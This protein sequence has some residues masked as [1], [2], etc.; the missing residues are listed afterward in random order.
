MK[1]YFIN[2]IF[3]S[4]VYGLF[5]G[6]STKIPDSNKLNLDINIVKINVWLN[7]MPGGRPSFHISGELGIK[8]ENR[9]RLEN[10]KLRQVVIYHDTLELIKIIP[11]FK[12]KNNLNDSTLHPGESKNFLISA[13]EKTDIKNLGNV[14]LI[15][16]LLMFSSEGKT[17]EYKIDNI[18]VERV[19]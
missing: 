10:L 19:Y 2:I 13:A 8:N 5:E 1:Y 7:L 17:F 12:I 15:N 18:E 14:K 11:L 3:I 4:I 6:C 9:E 16:L